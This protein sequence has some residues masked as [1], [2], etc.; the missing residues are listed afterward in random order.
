MLQQIDSYFDL[1][2]PPRLE[3]HHLND[4]NNKK[5]RMFLIEKSNFVRLNVDCNGLVKFGSHNRIDPSD[6]HDNNF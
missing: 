6:E 3:Y 2:N 5:T 1:T 4:N